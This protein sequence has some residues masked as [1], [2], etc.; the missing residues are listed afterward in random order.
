MAAADP[1]KSPERLKTPTEEVETS[2]EEAEAAGSGCSSAPPDETQAAGRPAEDGGADVGSA[3]V[4]SVAEVSVES[5]AGADKT[6]DRAAAEKM[7]EAP[8]GAERAFDW[9]E[10][11]EESEER[12]RAVTE[13]CGQSDA[14]E[15]AEE[16]EQ[17][18]RSGNTTTDGEKPATEENSHCDAA[19]D[20]PAKGV[21]V[22]E[23][24]QAA[25]DG[26]EDVELSPKQKKFS[27][28][29]KDCGKKFDCRE[30]FQLH[31]HF[32][33]HEDELTPLTCKECG[34]TFQHRSSLIKHRSQHKEK[35]EQQQQLL[36]TKKE[37]G[38]FQ[39]AECQRIFYSTDKLRDHNCSNTV[40]KPYHC[41]LCRQD[42]QFKASVTKHMSKHMMTRSN[43][44]IFKC[45][46]CNQIFPNVM[47]LRFHQKSHPALKPYECPECGMVFKH[48]SV[49]EDHRR[50]HADSGRSHTCSICGKAFK[51]T[52][53]ST[54]CVKTTRSA[55]RPTF[56]VPAT[57]RT[58]MLIHEAEYDKLD[59]STRP[60]TENNKRP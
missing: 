35:E 14:T 10:A 36:A 20:S 55:S 53:V 43:N 56:S 31:R 26:V 25:A 44:N 42:F 18:E 4:A 47:A 49:M 9:S 15:S 22:R 29:C 52:A 37:Y 1:A 57:L 39:C 12:A 24:K 46:E 38:R 6:P 50:K 8:S 58:H 48:Y 7:A 13:E 11:E 30:T 32:H 54:D 40:E 3:G 16:V 60:P 2:V 33:M 19:K 21:D 41:P 51:R 34:L 45:Q 27:I 59:R 5:G 23:E 28:E 17:E